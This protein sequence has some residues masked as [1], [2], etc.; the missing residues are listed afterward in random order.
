MDVSGIAI[1]SVNGV[2]VAA[3]APVANAQAPVAAPMQSI[4]PE[5]AYPFTPVTEL[6]SAPVQARN[7]ITFG[8]VGAWAVTSGMHLIA[9]SASIAQGSFRIPRLRK[10]LWLVRLEWQHLEWAKLILSGRS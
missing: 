8:I 2:P 4:L 6:P 5:W 7:V 10:S 3:A 9:L 1:T